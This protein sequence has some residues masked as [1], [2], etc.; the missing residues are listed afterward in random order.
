MIQKKYTSDQILGFK[1]EDWIFRTSSGY[2]GYDRKDYPGNEQMWIYENDY[3]ERKRLRDQYK[4]DY[5]LLYDFR[6]DQ[7]PFNGIGDH[8]IV[9]FLNKKYFIDETASTDLVP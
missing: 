9:E 3:W 6:F 1:Q 5:K 7:L 8:Q 2:A 4:A